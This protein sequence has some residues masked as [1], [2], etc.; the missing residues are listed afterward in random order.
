VSVFDAA[1]GKFLFAFG[2]KGGGTGEFRD[3]HGLG[4][5][6]DGDVIVSNYYGPVQRFTGDGKFRFEFAPGG[7]RDWVYFH[8]MTAD[9]RGNSYLAARHRDGR[10]AIAMYDNRGAFV[11]AW[12]ASTAEGEQGVKTALVDDAGLVY[13]AVES[14]DAHGVQV[15]RREP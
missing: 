12:A 3:A 13:V 2:K 14:K 7:F 8:S 11:T 15:Y 5:A 6:P 9:N 4:I 1:S 10:N